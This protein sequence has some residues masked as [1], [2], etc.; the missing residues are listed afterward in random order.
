MKILNLTTM[1]VNNKQNKNLN[2]GAC[3]AK[4]IVHYKEWSWSK[5]KI[6]ERS[7]T[8]MNDMAEYFHKMSDYELEKIANGNTYFVKVSSI[9]A[10]HKKLKEAVDIVRNKRAHIEEAIRSGNSLSYILQPELDRLDAKAADTK[11][12]EKLYKK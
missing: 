2:F 5:L 11:S 8:E 9:Q 7:E 10:A 4:N 6:L 3:F 1:Q 12:I